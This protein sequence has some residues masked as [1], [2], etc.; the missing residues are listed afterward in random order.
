VEGTDIPDSARVAALYA[1]GAIGLR[2]ARL[3]EGVIGTCF[4]GEPVSAEERAGV[5][6]VRPKVTGRAWITGFHQFVL[7]PEDPLPE[8]FRVGH[9]PRPAPDPESWS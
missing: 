4:I 5:L 1:K 8:G 6:Y 9:P 3:F 2:E 7:D